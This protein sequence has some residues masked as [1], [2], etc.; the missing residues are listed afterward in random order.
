MAV[1][2]FHV[3]PLW[4]L[5]WSALPGQERISSQ[6][7]AA[8]LLALLGLVL[9]TGT[10]SALWQ[11]QAHATRPTYLLGVAL[12]LLG[13]LCTAAVTLI[14]QGCSGT[15]RSPP[16]PW[17]GGSACWAPC[18]CGSGR[19]STAGPHGRQLAVAGRPGTGPHGPGLYA[20]LRRHGPPAHQ[21]RGAAAVPL[22]RRGTADRRTAAGPAPG[23]RALA[24]PGH[25]R[26][27]RGLGRTAG[28]APALISSRE[29]DAA[30]HRTASSGIRH[31]PSRNQAGISWHPP[32]CGF[33]GWPQCPVARGR[34]RP[35]AG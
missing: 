7:V 8:V 21:P 20:D 12:C 5:L 16:A 3:Q 11:D 2:L 1:V 22:P 33:L 35:S 18:C 25:H 30:R 19:C 10:L 28:R 24:G 6:R 4:L 27:R 34:G 26:L 15:S 29:P 23:W 9:A 32:A 17:P 31:A 14:A 13:A